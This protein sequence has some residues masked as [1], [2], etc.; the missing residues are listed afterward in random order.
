VPAKSG[1]KVK[2]ALKTLAG[3]AG[4]AGA[5]YLGHKGAKSFRSSHPNRGQDIALNDLL[6]QAMI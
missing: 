2:T 1:S 5:A 6:E 4:L 3:L